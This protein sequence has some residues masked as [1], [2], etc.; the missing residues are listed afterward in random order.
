MLTK[1]CGHTEAFLRSGF[2][3]PMSGPIPFITSGDSSKAVN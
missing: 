3:Y 2:E 1:V